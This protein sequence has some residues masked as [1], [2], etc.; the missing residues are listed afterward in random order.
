MEKE[1]LETKAPIFKENNSLDASLLT[2]D[3]PTLIEKMKVKHIWAKG[4]PNSMILLKSPEKQIVL[5][6]LYK[7]IGIKSFQSNDSV[8]I[9]IVE[10]KLKFNTRKE[11]VILEKG[12]LLTLHE[13]MK[14]SLTTKT[15]TVFLL[16]IASGSLQT[17]E[18]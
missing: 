11:S 1:S 5:I 13:N 18:N 15:E 7:E 17:R 9:Q 6:A 16:T 2:F 4:E 8:T 3:L 10:G 12:Q 14:Y